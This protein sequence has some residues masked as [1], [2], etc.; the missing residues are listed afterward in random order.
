MPDHFFPPVRQESHTFQ[1]CLPGHIVTLPG[2][3]SKGQ[4]E[5]NHRTRSAYAAKAHPPRIDAR[6]ISLQQETGG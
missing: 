5:D 6:H 2:H 1:T 4:N 3:I